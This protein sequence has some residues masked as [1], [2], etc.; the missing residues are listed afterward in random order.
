MVYRPKDPTP[1]KS[2]EVANANDADNAYDEE[3]E[4]ASATGAQADAIAN[5]VLDTQDS[6]IEDAEGDNDEDRAEEEATVAALSAPKEPEKAKAQP[7]ASNDC[8]KAQAQPAQAPVNPAAAGQMPNMLGQMAG[9]NPMMM[10]GM[11]PNMMAPGQPMGGQPG[12]NVPALTPEQQALVN[13]QI[14]MWQ[15]H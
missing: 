7:A 4:E 9:V 10:G 13:Q 5:Q 2:E 3:D 14:M 6:K 12:S 15:Q 11:P 8:S 1:E